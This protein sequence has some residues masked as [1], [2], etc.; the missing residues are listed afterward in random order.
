[1]NNLT[2]E[3]FKTIS[4]DV[5]NINKLDLKVG[6]KYVFD[7]Y[8]DWCVPCKN[9]KPVLESISDEYNDVEFYKV[10]IDTEAELTQM[11]KIRSIPTLVFISTDGTTTLTQGT[12]LKP[13]LKEI[14]DNLN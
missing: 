7:F 12:V 14:L 13:K 5:T 11:F 2:L 9:L 4:N 8:A 3:Q 10:D 6:K 1:M